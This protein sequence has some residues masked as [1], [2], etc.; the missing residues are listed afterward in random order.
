V[1]ETP[2]R[3][4][5]LVID[6]DAPIRDLVCRLLQRMAFDTDGA[7]TGDE[8]LA[9]LG[10]GCYDLV[11]TDLMMPGLTGWDVAEAVRTRAPGVGIIL[12]TGSLGAVDPG[13]VGRLA[14]TVLPKPFE[15][16]QL[17]RAVD[18]A[19]Q[20]AVGAEVAASVAPG[21]PPVA[22][23]SRALQVEPGGSI[24]DG[25]AALRQLAAS[26]EEM[27]ARLETA[28]KDREALE[29]RF[30]QLAGEYERH[31]ATHGAL[32]RAYQALLE[33]LALAEVEREALRREHERTEQ[34]LETA[35]RQA[36]QMCQERDAL[37]RD[38]AAAPGRPGA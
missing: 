14:L 19:L 30:R 35:R 13:R 7:A 32:V 37:R 4:R 23:E 11:V 28:T 5:G 16:Q 31:R 3:R 26:L 24:R 10:R 38:P 29:A 34:A 1:S 2:G 17:A 9:L 6:D 25:G 27:A 33:V 15:P 8:G 36:A 18:A 21:R 20:P 22:A 12:T